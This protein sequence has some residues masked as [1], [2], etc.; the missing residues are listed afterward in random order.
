[1]A[2]LLRFIATPLVLLR[3]PRALGEHT[4]EV[5]AVIF[6]AVSSSSDAAKTQIFLVGFATLVNVWHLAD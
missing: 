4:G 3:A 2:S 5:Q 1:M 6:G